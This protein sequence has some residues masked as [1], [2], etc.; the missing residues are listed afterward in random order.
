MKSNLPERIFLSG[1]PGSRWSGIAQVLEQL[2]GFNTS[3]RTP[4][5]EYSHSEYSGHKGAYF[6]PGMEFEP[7][8][9]VDYIDSAWTHS[10]GCRIVKSHEWCEMLQDVHNTFPKD[11][12]LLVHRQHKQCYNWWTAAGGY[13]ISY[14][15]YSSYDDLPTIIKRQNQA[16]MRWVFEKH[17]PLERFNPYWVEREFDQNIDFDASPWEDVFVTL[18]KP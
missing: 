13:D 2:P 4:E 16:I 14:P 3:D 6:G 8:L 10:N 15:N 12:I 7:I 1:A 9:D 17:C 18:W 11:W 5:R